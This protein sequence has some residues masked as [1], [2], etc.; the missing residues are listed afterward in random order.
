MMPD[1]KPAYVIAEVEVTDPNAFADY[2]AKAVPTLGEYNARFVARSKAHSKEGTAPVGEIVL[3]AF[4]SL[5]DA[6]RW[7]GSP[8]YTVCIPLRQRAAN[9]RLFI[10]EGEPL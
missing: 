1:K 7:Y 9:T 4:D 8:S 3:L 2:V 6:E 10:I 5:A